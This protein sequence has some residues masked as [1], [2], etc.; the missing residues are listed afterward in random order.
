M[1]AVVAVSCCSS[2]MPGFSC[3]PESRGGRS[4][5]SQAYRCPGGWYTIRPWPREEARLSRAGS[6]RARRGKAGLRQ[7]PAFGTGGP[8]GDEDGVWQRSLRCRAAAAECRDF[9]ARLRAAAVGAFSVRR[10][11]C[12]GGWYTIRPLPREESRLIRVR[13]QSGHVTEKAGL[14]GR[15]AGRR[16]RAL[17]YA[18]LRYSSGQT[19]ASIASRSLSRSA[20]TNSIKR[21]ICGAG[22]PT[23]VGKSTSRISI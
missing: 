9:L 14:R 20:P 5:L 18:L 4:V 2:R 3:T 13:V 10:I 1:A 23:S 8:D 7:S 11:G 22:S 21:S 15:A 17:T 12:P 6:E 19:A 16:S